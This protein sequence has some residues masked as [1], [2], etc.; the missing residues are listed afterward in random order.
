MRWKTAGLWAL[1]LSVMTGCD[2]GFTKGG[3]IDRAV[4]QDVMELYR[5]PCSKQE[6][7]KLCG[8]QNK[9]SPDCIRVCG[10]QQ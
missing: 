6:L 2:D 8:G 1:S 10:Q 5:K 9:N 3:R 4:H 7:A